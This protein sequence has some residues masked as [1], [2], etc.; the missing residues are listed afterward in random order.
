[1]GRYG[2]NGNRNRY[3]G[4][5]N[6]NGG[7]RKKV[8]CWLDNHPI[9]GKVYKWNGHS[10]CKKSHDILCAKFISGKKLQQKIIKS[11]QPPEKK[12]FFARLLGM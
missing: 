8:M 1:M 11:M 10:V 9:Y 3:K 4:K 12:G 7:G 2:G 6:G 5:R